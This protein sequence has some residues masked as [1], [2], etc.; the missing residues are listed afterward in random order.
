MKIPTEPVGSIPRPPALLEAITVSSDTGGTAEELV[1]L[2]DTAIRDTLAEFEAT[3]SPVITDGEQG[4]YPDFVSYPLHGLNNIKPDG[5][6]IPDIAGSCQR[7]PCLTAGPFKYGRYA[8]SYLELARQYTRAPLKQAII[9]PAILT[10]LYPPE[11]LPDYSREDFLEDLLQEHKT[12]IRRCLDKGAE[13]IQIDFI[14]AGLA[15]RLDPRGELLNSF[16]YLANLALEGLT[17]DECKRIGMH[18]CPGSHGSS[19][20]GTTAEYAALLPSLLET[21]TGSFYIALAG[22]SDRARILETLRDHVKPGQRIFIGVTNPADPRIETAEDVKQCIMD[23][24]KY[25]PPEQLGTTDDCGFAPYAVHA[26]TTREQAFAK[27]RSRVAGTDLANDLL[28]LA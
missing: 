25:I 13:K 19:D 14:E 5:L 3:G 20:S 28:G 10:L 21:L 27:I 12:E 15:V 24:V 11:P 2:I 6:H 23:A 17:S 8:D 18:I 26:E 1:A 16:I 7:L 9:S 22:M 4:K